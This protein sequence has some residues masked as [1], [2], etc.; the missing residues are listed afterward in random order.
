MPEGDRRDQI[1]GIYNMINGKYS[2]KTVMH[3]VISGP[4]VKNHS[5]PSTVNPT[6]GFYINTFHT[7]SVVLEFDNF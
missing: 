3:H 5:G 4:S 6:S 1:L 2:K 7:D